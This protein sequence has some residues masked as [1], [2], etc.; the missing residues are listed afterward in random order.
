MN[1]ANN[2]SGQEYKGPG[3]TLTVFTEDEEMKVANSLLTTLPSATFPR[4]G[5]RWS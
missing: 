3:R 2:W 1:S 4:S 5:P